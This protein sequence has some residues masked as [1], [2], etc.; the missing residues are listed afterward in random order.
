MSSVN[1]CLNA[2]GSLFGE[3]FCNETSDGAG[4][5]CSFIRM[6]KQERVNYQQWE[7]RGQSR[8]VVRETGRV[9]RAGSRY[10][11]P[12]KKRSESGQPAEYHRIEE[13]GRVITRKHTMDRK[14]LRGGSRGKSRLRNG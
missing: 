9:V 12:G 11:S 13:R 6:V 4:S 1:N 3:V 2:A 14:T 8:D 7:Q 10:Q 5:I